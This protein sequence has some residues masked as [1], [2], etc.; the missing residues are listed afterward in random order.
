LDI[1]SLEDNIT[2]P[3]NVRMHL[4]SV[5]ASYLKNGVVSYTTAKTVQCETV[6]EYQGMVL[7]PEMSLLFV[8]L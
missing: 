1:L 2:F 7:H 8:S 5:L 4:S 6:P 3:Q